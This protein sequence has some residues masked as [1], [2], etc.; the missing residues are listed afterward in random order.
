MKLLL[1]TFALCLTFCASRAESQTFKTLVQFTGS[2]GTASGAT[3][4]GSLVVSGTTLYGMTSAG[5]AHFDGNIFSVGMDG[6][7]FQN[8]LSFTGSSG[9]ALGNKPG[10]SLTLSG[11]TLYGMTNLGG[12][13][14]KGN[15]FSIATDGTGYQNLLS[16]TGAGGTA[17][18]AQPNGD[19]TLSGTT[20]Y[21]ITSGLGASNGNIFS[22]GTDGTS[23]HNLV[24]FT[25][26]GG[27]ANGAKPFGSL[28]LSGSSFYAMPNLGGSAH[29]G[30]I[31]SVG[32]DG[33]N[34]QIPV[35]FTGAS[36][37]AIGAAPE[38]SLTL[39]GTT[40]YGM[41]SGLSGSGAFNGNIFSVGTDGTNYRNLVTFTGTSGTAS[42]A[43]PFG[44]L[45]LSGTTLYGMANSGGSMNRGD[46]FSIGIDGSS[47]HDLYNFVGT[48]DIGDGA[49]PY[50]N[51]ILSGGTLFGMT[52][53]QHTVLTSNGTVFALTLPSS[54]PEPCTLALA[55]GGAAA[56]VAYRWRR[57]RSAGRNRLE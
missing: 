9:A 11:S 48:P 18:G 37:T 42:G 46:V 57:R 20:L 24:A 14:G 50:G 29:V 8:L 33:T 41:T 32:T 27:T 43:N 40:L 6:T 34:Y 2:G 19:L 45:L 1:I 12:T 4:F 38:G 7:N 51:L 35:S 49:N 55:G 30:T 28:A 3:P 22:V 53:G 52:S 47:F 21:G 36:G 39:S 56:V 16:F 25:S 31:F 23:Y 15:V 13:N 26:N 17:S 54:T 10:G 44:S 5:A